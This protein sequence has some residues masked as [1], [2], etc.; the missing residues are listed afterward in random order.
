MEQKDIDPEDLIYLEE[1]LLRD[2]LV[3]VLFL[4]YGNEKSQWILEKLSKP[5]SKNFLHDY[6]T[7]HT[8][9][10]TSVV[11]ALTITKQYQI[12]DFLGID[13]GDARLHL[14]TNGSVINAGLRLLY[15]L[16]ESLTQEAHDALMSHIKV[17]CEPARACKEELLE[18]FLLHSIAK[19]L[20]KLS[21]SIEN[22]DFSLITNF[23]H[24]HAFDDIDEVINK[25]PKKS[26]SLDNSNNNSFNTIDLS[27][28]TSGKVQSLLGQY[29]CAK[30][31]VLIIN[32]QTFVRDSNPEVQHMLPDH[33]LNLRKGTDQ[34]MKALQFVFENFDFD[35]VV[36]NDL[37][38]Y[39]ILVEVNKATKKAS[40]VDGLIVCILSHGHEGV[41]FGHNSIPVPVNGKHGIKTVM[42]SKLL[43]SKPKILLI[44]ACQGEN[45]QQSVKKFVTKLEDDGPTQSRFT[46]GSIHADFL[47]FWS[48]I[49]GF[50]S[51]RHVDDGSWF[52]QEFVKKIRE[53]YKDQHLMDICTSVI[54][55]VSLKRG[56]N[57][58]CMLPK[59]EATFTKNFRFPETKMDSSC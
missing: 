1:D 6:A 46:S 24:K 2:D 42:A 57:N 27:A 54:N 29:K 48:T 37:K 8:Y 58:E 56:Y 4:L 38:H 40:M 36:K 19:K 9:W 25:F 30:M 50:A 26:N 11:E 35:V 21:S 7:H 14:R 53:L 52:I 5:D 51:V 33:Q 41:I 32:Q 3:S 59:L 17:K 34:D 49:E 16:C 45:L 12:I 22:S 44:Q 47:T 31:H 15:E 23:F 39:E 13:H 18:F 55:E 28:S 20:I 10:K 43:L